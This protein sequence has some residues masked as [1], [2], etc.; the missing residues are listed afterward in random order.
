[1][2][3]SKRTKK[4]DENQGQQDF[5]EIA[6]INNLQERNQISREQKIDAVRYSNAAT[7][8]SQAKITR[9]KWEKMKESNMVRVISFC[10]IQKKE[11]YRDPVER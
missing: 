10:K 6:K 8:T 11:T 1:L 7:K 3:D 4:K 2:H 9:N 5:L